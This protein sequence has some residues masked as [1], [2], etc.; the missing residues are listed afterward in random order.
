MN[1][2]KIIVLLNLIL[3][4][5]SFPLLK[6]QSL[7]NNIDQAEFNYKNEE[8]TLAAQFYKKAWEKVVTKTD[9]L[10]HAAFSFYQGGQMEDAIQ[11]YEILAAES[12]KHEAKSFYYLALASK[13][14]G[15][16]RDATDYY[17]AYYKKL[18]SKDK[19]RILIRNEISRCL[20]G[21]KLA[22]LQPVAIVES[23][24]ANINSNNEE[25]NIIPSVNFTDRFYFSAIRAENEGGKRN[26]EGKADEKSGILRSDLFIAE[27]ESGSWKPIKKMNT[28]INGTKHDAILD[29]IN[30]GES[31]VYFQSWNQNE[32]D[33]KIH[34]LS[35][36]SNKK[37]DENLFK[38]LIYG[39]IGDKYMSVF[40]DSVVIFSSKRLGGYGGFD[41]Y[42]SIL[43]NGK[44]STPKNLGNKI[45]TPYN[46]ISPFIAKDGL[47]LY[48]SSDNLQSI[49]GY[50]I[51]RTIF[52]AES[53][54]W[55][56]AE[57]IGLPVNSGANDYSFRLTPDGLSGV[58]TSDRKKNSKGKQDIFIAYFKQELEEQYYPSNGT[59]L[60]LLFEPKNENETAP[61]SN[62]SNTAKQP[63]EALNKVYKDYIVEPV[64]YVDDKFIKEAK[65]IK[66]VDQLQSMMK[67]NPELKIQLMAHAYEENSAPLNL[68]YS[69]KK[70]EQISALIEEQGI[71][72][73][74]IQV[75]GFGNY[76]PNAKPEINNTKYEIS[77]KWNKRIELNIISADT[78][79]ARI[80]YSSPAIPEYL[81]MPPSKNLKNI[82]STLF[83][84]IL[85]GE[86]EQVLNSDILKKKDHPTFV[87]FDPKSKKYQYYYGIETKFRDAESIFTKIKENSKL[88]IVPLLQ[89]SIIERKEVINFVEKYPDLILYINFMNNQK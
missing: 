7:S 10:Q 61:K 86:S 52:K 49:G 24:G 1:S 2:Q 79:L 13:E 70:A 17:K 40:Q 28:L 35:S 77:E 58:F 73:E 78:S 69:I 65:T 88:K 4:I 39:E 84:T 43:R 36:E 60:S 25:Y 41:L 42:I 67:V 37:V 26:N 5:F 12:S 19:E 64:F 50:D 82:F 80:S 74:K 27:K 63:N 3:I 85:I 32:G 54:I 66:Q 14:I 76:F 11:A 68:Y 55:D 46:E 16:Y 87:Y 47:T 48:Y 81:K 56:Q 53:G 8:F 33:I 21:V 31:M 20:E 18:S 45:N 89:G 59:M 9:L 51:F 23:I 75:Y 38:G 71:P 6:A 44:W 30:D 83:Y 34:N 72:K 22:K 15:N 29:F 57:N 62:I